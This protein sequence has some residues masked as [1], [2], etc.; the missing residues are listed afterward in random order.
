MNVLMRGFAVI[1]ALLGSVLPALSD[2]ALYYVAN[3]RPPDAFLALRT[4]PTSSAGARIMAMP[5]RT[6]APGSGAAKKTAGGASKSRLRGKKAGRWP[7]R[8]IA[9]GSNAA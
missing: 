7:P 2:N 9:T 3:T 1:A 4:Q 6:A 8:A 5:N